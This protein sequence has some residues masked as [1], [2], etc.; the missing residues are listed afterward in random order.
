MTKRILIRSALFALSIILFNSLS[1]AQSSYSDY[2]SSDKMRVYRE[3]FNNTS[4]EWEIYVSGQRM[5]KVNN[6]TYDW[7][8]LNDKAQAKYISI[9]GMD[10]NR[11]WQLEIRMKHLNGKK[12]SS[13]DFLWDREP[14]NSNKCHFGFTGEGKYNLSEYDKGYQ[15]I[16]GFT[17]SSFV[18][19][20]TFNKITVRKV[21]SNCYFFFNER[22][23]TSRRY[24]RI[25]GDY[26]GFMVPPNSTLQVDYLEASYLNSSSASNSF[27]TS[28]TPT[29]AYVGVMSKYNG[30][31]KQR[32]KTRD[33]FPKEEIK[34]DWDEGY[35]IS[36]IS[37]DNEKWTLISSKG[38]GFTLQRWATRVDFPKEKI[39]EL[40]NESYRVTELNYGNGVWALVMSKGSGF[41]KQRWATSS[42]FPREKIKEFGDEG[43]YITELI[44][45][46]DR[47]AL[48]SSKDEDIVGQRWFKKSQFPKKDLEEQIN[49]GYNVT[50][51]E[52]H[53][54]FWILI[55][56]KY[57]TL[58]PQQWFTDNTFP[59]DKIRE[60]W[61]QGFYLTD[62]TYGITSA[63][64]NEVSNVSKTSYKTSKPLID[65]LVG[66]W[67]GGVPDE[68]EKG[69][70]IFD[71]DLYATMITD[72]DTIG[73]KNYY[74]S[75]V[76]IDLRYSI[77]TSVSP[78]QLDL[79]F[80]AGETNFGAMKGIIRMIDDNTFELKLAT[81]LGNS[82]P[83]AF[84]D[85][86]DS[87]VALFKR[88]N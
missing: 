15:T 67:Y 28:N 11:D 74:E 79:F 58:K 66:K 35:Y 82:R 31:T 56:T 37:Y 69:Y 85:E 41:G 55:M 36:D 32:W 59:K 20:S 72:K 54:G 49:Q 26:V 2:T 45:G 24:K 46:N 30:Y 5:G 6:G 70:F 75:G 38:T 43:L 42:D 22:F 40:W 47:W 80:K 34:K 4:S 84:I 12:N 62:I 1:L 21:G 73:G 3:D 19:K 60:Y 18:G 14:G 16:V 10:W 44:Y 88:V 39:K 13:N 83:T 51:L 77:N 8:S 64:S 17:A 65:L 53:N 48:V 63:R 68:N 87:K 33:A 23:I 29:V 27:N 9:P 52:Y 71:K 86:K 25:K 76:K 81:Q 50:Q 61:N 57:A 7:I 78:K